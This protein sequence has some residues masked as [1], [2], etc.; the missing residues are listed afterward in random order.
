MLKIGNLRVSYGNIVALRGVSLDVAEGEIVAVIG[1]N[2]AGKST[3]LLT[4]AGVAC[5][6]AAARFTS[7]VADPGPRAGTAGRHGHV[8]GA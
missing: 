7:T 5:A 8:A 6:P 4:L 3:L 2:G 1:P